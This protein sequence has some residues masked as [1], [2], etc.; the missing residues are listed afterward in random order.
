MKLMSY[1]E[2]HKLAK[3]VTFYNAVTAQE[4]TNYFK[5]INFLKALAAQQAAAAAAQQ[6]SAAAGSSSGR[7]RRPHASR[8]GS[9]PCPVGWWF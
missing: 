1:A 5:E 2:A 7:G 9:S 3:V 6:A 4:E 8:G